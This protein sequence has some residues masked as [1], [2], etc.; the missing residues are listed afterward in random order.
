MIKRGYF[1][2]VFAKKSILPSL[3]DIQINRNRKSVVLHNLPQARGKLIQAMGKLIHVVQ[4]N[5]IWYF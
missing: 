4:T 3:E 1:R 5:I 2:S